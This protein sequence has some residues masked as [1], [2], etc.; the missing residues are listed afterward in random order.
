LTTF[1]NCKVRRDFARPRKVYEISQFIATFTE[2]KVFLLP[3]RR[4]KLLRCPLN[5]FLF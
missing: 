4:R 5:L 3:W 2:K 1:Q